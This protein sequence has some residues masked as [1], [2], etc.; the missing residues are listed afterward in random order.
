MPGTVSSGGTFG[1][2]CGGQIGCGGVVHATTS[3]IDSGS[4]ASAIEVQSLADV[5]G[6]SGTGETS[7]AGGVT[8]DSR[9]DNADSAR[10]GHAGTE[11][12]VVSVAA[13]ATTTNA[14]SVTT[15]TTTATSASS[16]RRDGRSSDGD[17]AR[18]GNSATGSTRSAVGAR[19][20]G[21]PGGQEASGATITADTAGIAR[22]GRSGD[23]ERAGVG[24]AT[25]STSSAAVLARSAVVVLTARGACGANTTGAGGIARNGRSGNGK[26]ARV[27]D[28]ATEAAIATRGAMPTVVFAETNSPVNPGLTDAGSVPR[29]S[30]GGDSEVAGVVDSAT[31]GTLAIGD[32]E[33]FNRDRDRAGSDREH[34]SRFATIHDG[35]GGPSSDDGER[36]QA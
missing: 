21:V 17:R 6:A 33:V 1:H 35:D 24:N 28:T 29:D 25:T 5:A 19:A 18:V 13:M 2:D 10:V 23:G 9:G 16:I 11:A 14:T 22:D 26:S 30:R 15:A 27:L 36:V 20:S 7:G 32:G 34:R 31:V 3:S 12:T 4:A 8:R